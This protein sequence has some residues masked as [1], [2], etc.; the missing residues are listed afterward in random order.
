MIDCHVGVHRYHDIL[1][2]SLLISRLFV[3]HCLTTHKEVR[4]AHCPQGKELKEKY[5]PA[6]FLKN[7]SPFAI[8]LE[9]HTKDS[10]K[11]LLFTK[12]TPILTCYLHFTLNINAFDNF[13][14]C[15]Y[16]MNSLIEKPEKRKNFD[17]KN[18]IFLT[19]KNFLL[20]NNIHYTPL[21]LY[22]FLT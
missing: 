22:Y 19:L 3:Q 18:T 15:C 9:R 5:E 17:M 1:S 6:L 11:G 16:R 14:M 10:Q 4:T 21:I 12:I 8:I 20:R 7:F 2:D 13:L